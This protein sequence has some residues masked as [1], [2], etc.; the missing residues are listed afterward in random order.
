MARG[1]PWTRDE[2]IVAMNLYCKLPFGLL[3]QRN[4][5]VIRLAK[6]LD[7]TPGSV[8]M[9]LCNLASLDP[10]HQARGIMGLTGASQGDRDVW[11]EFHSDW[12]R[13]AYE[14]EK[15]SAKLAGIPVER[16]A[17]IDETELPREGKERE[18]LVKQR[19]NQHFFRA[20]VLAAYNG[21]CC[22][23]D[24]EI[25]GLLCA[26][27]VVPWA[28]DKPNRMNPRN[29]LCLNALHDRAFD[30][31]LITLTLDFKVQISGVLKRAKPSAARFWLTDFDNAPIRTPEKFTP[32]TKFIAWHRA[33][34]FQGD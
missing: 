5:D 21:R 26:S 28:K 8:A 18:R 4:P 30:R 31:G 12:D 27:H 24:L 32:D 25:R 17:E 19:V 16:L 23:T 10:V 34:V 20:A 13:L 2:L 29:G 11:A 14:S 1:K 22:I 7:R 9:K 6:R 3:H 33:H 15:L